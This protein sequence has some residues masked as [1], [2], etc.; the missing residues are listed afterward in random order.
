[1]SFVL[2]VMSSFIGCWQSEQSCAVLTGPVA[3][4]LNGIFGTPIKRHERILPLD[5]RR[6]RLSEDAGEREPP[7]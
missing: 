1:M 7:A 5:Q 3:C 4:E 6:I 2:M